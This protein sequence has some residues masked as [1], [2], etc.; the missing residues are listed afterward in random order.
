MI[1][2]RLFKYT[3]YYSH[4]AILRSIR[5]I[6]DSRP[7]LLRQ[8]VPTILLMDGAPPTEPSPSRRGRYDRSANAAERASRARATLLDATAAVLLEHGSAASVSEIVRRAHLGRNTFYEHFTDLAAARG[9]VDDFAADLLA[10]HARAR[11]TDAHTPFERLRAIAHAWTEAAAESP[12]NFRVACA[13]AP[14]HTAACVDQA[15][16][17]LHA[18]IADAISVGALPPRDVELHAAALA[19]VFAALTVLPLEKVGVT[20]PPLGDALSDLVTRCLR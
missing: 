3:H 17:L 11:L 15:R 6:D 19:A 5:P 12:A 10:L 9:A 13:T 2:L 8:N 20:Q 1:H 7:L 4:F 14:I 18:E 16:R